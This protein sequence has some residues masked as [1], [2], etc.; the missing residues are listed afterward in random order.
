MTFFVALWKF[1]KK[2]YMT[3]GKYHFTLNYEAF[4]YVQFRSS[5]MG[6]RG[7]MW[8]KQNL[9]PQDGWYKRSCKDLQGTLT[10][11]METPIWNLQ[12]ILFSFSTSLG[13]KVCDYFHVLSLL[14]FTFLNLCY[15]WNEWNFQCLLFRKDLIV[16]YVFLEQPFACVSLNRNDR[17]R[18]IHTDKEVI[19]AVEAVV[20]DVWA[21]RGGVQEVKDER[22]LCYELK[23]K[24]YP[25]WATGSVS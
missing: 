20:R 22:P 16:D 5:L 25:W 1:T 17:L 7:A 11:F 12:Q 4:I 18:L 24:G 6:V 2:S 3:L 10:Y 19:D 23:L 13:Y 21:P 14:R 8:I 9:V 15:L